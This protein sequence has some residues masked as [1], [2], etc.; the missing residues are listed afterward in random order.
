MEKAEK[1]GGATAP[2]PE[3]DESD[4]EGMGSQDG[5]EVAA[6]SDGEMHDK[7][8]KQGVEAI[9]KETGKSLKRGKTMAMKEAISTAKKHDIDKKTVAEAEKLLQD[10]KK[11]QWQEEVELEVQQFFDGSNVKDIPFCEKVLTKVKDAECKV[12]VLQR[13][14][15]HLEML[16]ITRELE[17]DEVKQAREQLKQSCRQFV[18]AAVA[19]DGRRITILNLE[20]GN[21]IPANVSLD[22]P[23]E[24]MTVVH[25]SGNEHDIFI[26]LVSLNAFN[27]KDDGKI[28][29]S[30]GFEALEVDDRDCVVAMRYETNEKEKGVMC[31]VEREITERDRLREAII[32]LMTICKS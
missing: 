4:L 20:T 7:D 5:S 18:H 17:L 10:H 32:T 30:K 29:Q 8:V 24:N 9:L 1:S 21:K 27:A 23:L 16:I 12:E 19:G 15:D 31:I 14:S 2:A 13:V 22:P 26:P 11:R 3:M 25:L 6:S 28:R